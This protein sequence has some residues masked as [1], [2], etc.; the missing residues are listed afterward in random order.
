MLALLSGC[1]P[2]PESMQAPIDVR[3]DMPRVSLAGGLRAA[4]LDASAPPDGSP[5][6]CAGTVHEELGGDG[7]AVALLSA[8]IRTEE[9][10]GDIDDDG[11]LKAAAKRLAGDAAVRQAAE[12]VGARYLIAVFGPVLGEATALPTPGIHGGDYSATLSR[13]QQAVKAAATVVD[14]ADASRVWT[15]RGEGT[16]TTEFGLALLLPMWAVTLGVGE[17]T[18][19]ALGRTLRH[20]FAL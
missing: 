10:P 8:E 7:G 17:R 19:R 15:I 14:L 6:S 1:L 3:D 4:L 9:P 2:I 12:Q 18:C 11:Q 16:R 5:S 13:K 20:G